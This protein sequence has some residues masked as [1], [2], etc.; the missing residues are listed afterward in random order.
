MI[1]TKARRLRLEFNTEGRK[2]RRLYGTV[3]L[4]NAGAQEVSKCTGTLIQFAPTRLLMPSR[5]YLVSILPRPR[6]CI[7]ATTR[8]P[9]HCF[10]FNGFGIPWPL[11][12]P[13]NFHKY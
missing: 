1:C 8:R 6:T 10:V 7:A 5:G 3:P 12:E 4:R 11:T 13:Q 2:A 9:R